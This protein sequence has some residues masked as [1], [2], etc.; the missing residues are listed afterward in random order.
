MLQLAQIRFTK[1]AHSAEKNYTK[2]LSLKKSAVAFYKRGNAKYMSFQIADAIN[3]YT[4]AIIW[5]PSYAK[6]YRNRGIARYETCKTG[7][8]SDLKKAGNLG[9][10]KAYNEYQRIKNKDECE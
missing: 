4:N 3:D 5:N 7:A 2:S 1:S 10:T 6:A 9:D 8:C